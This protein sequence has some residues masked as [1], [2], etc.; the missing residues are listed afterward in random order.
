M[1]RLKHIF[2]DDGEEYEIQLNQ[3]FITVC[4]DCCLVH[5]DIY[6]IRNG[7]L[8]CKTKRDNRATGQYRRHN[9][10]VIVEKSNKAIEP[11]AKDGGS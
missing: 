3:D 1:P 4:C 8:F 2:H 7:K 5:R 10:N 11:T 6:T 9:E